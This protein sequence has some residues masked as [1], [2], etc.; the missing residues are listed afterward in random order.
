MLNYSTGSYEFLVN[1]LDLY[2]YMVNVLIV[3]IATWDYAL[4]NI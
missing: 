1:F 4:R 2:F 3:F